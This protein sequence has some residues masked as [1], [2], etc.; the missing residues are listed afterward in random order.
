MQQISTAINA[1]AGEL[2]AMGKRARATYE[3]EFAVKIGVQRIED[4]LSCPA[5][6][7]DVA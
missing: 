2:E 4:L 1:G 7:A 3:V 5:P 6:R